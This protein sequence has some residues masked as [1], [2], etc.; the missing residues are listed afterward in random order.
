MHTEKAKPWRTLGLDVLSIVG[1]GTEHARAPTP[2]SVLSQL[3]ETEPQC[4][5][6][7]VAAGLIKDCIS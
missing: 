4:L 3:A 5:A 6:R 2:L 1:P 7:H